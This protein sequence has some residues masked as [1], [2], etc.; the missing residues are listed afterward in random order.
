MKIARQP[1]KA[2]NKG[3]PLKSGSRG[4]CC[5][6]PLVPPSRDNSCQWEFNSK[7][8][9]LNSPAQLTCRSSPPIH[10]QA[11]RCPWRKLVAQMIQDPTGSQACIDSASNTCPHH[12]TQQAKT[13]EALPI[14]QIHYVYFLKHPSHP[15]TCI[16]SQLP[17]PT[18]PALLLVMPLPGRASGHLRRVDAQR[19]VCQVRRRRRGGAELGRGARGQQMLGRA[20]DVDGHLGAKRKE[21]GHHTGHQCPIIMFLGSC[22]GIVQGPIIKQ[23]IPR[24]AT[25]MLLR[26]CSKRSTALRLR[27]AISDQTC[28]GPG[29]HCHPGI[30]TRHPSVV[31]KNKKHKYRTIV[32]VLVPVLVKHL[33]YWYQYGSKPW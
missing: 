31:L 6:T 26:T 10:Q 9:L 14:N 7:G 18:A 2:S 15:A 27:L 5:L 22:T 32:L 29:D 4:T 23:R 1:C 30:G 16:N 33:E 20:G 25:L 11:R 8:G 21:G 19:R 13:Y 24:C 12:N 17:H 3:K 28:L